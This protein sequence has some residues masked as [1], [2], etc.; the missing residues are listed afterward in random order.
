MAKLF[1][2]ALL[3][4]SNLIELFYFSRVDSWTKLTETRWSNLIPY[5]THIWKK[6]IVKVKHYRWLFLVFVYSSTEFSSRR[7]PNERFIIWTK[8]NHV[9]SILIPKQTSCDNDNQEKKMWVSCK[10]RSSVSMPAH[11]T[12]PTTLTSN[13]W[14]GSIY[15]IYLLLLSMEVT[16]ETIWHKFIDLIHCW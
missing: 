8:E 16:M 11:T 13:F 14:L 1:L 15:A 12:P 3:T 4:K 9:E 6:I 10:I 2:L 5:P 7:E